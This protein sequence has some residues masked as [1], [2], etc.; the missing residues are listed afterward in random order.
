MTKSYSTA[1]LIQ[2]IRDYMKQHFK[3][4]QAHHFCFD[5]PLSPKSKK[6][7]FIIMGLNPAEPK[8]PDKSKKTPTE[9][10]RE[11]D[12]YEKF[13]HGRREDIPW[14]KLCYEMAGSKNIVVS[15][16]FFWSSKNKKQLDERYGRLDGKNPHFHFCTRINKALIN[17]HKPK[18]IIVAGLGNKDL[19][20]KLFEFK[21]EKSVHTAKGH[22]LIEKCRDKN[23]NLWI[24]T[25]HWTGSFG[26]SNEEKK[27][28]QDF[29]KD[30]CK[31]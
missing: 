4:Q 21:V 11:F 6:V 20:N 13:H 30:E 2:E 15:E 28:I 5:L 29:I 14:T 7:D 3:L 18:A 25:K 31:F 17:F 8:N 9:E 27:T 26:F 22:R 19:S 24:F 16:F 1:H 10:T 23:K 12:Y